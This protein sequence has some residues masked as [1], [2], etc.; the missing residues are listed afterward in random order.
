MTRIDCSALLFDLDGVLINSTPA[1]ARVWSQWAIEHGFSS[2]EVVGYAQGRPSIAT[3]RHFLP[4]TDHQAKN[5]EVER[6]EMED[7]DGVIPLPGA[8]ELL[9]SLP[10]DRWT[11]ATSCT[12][13]LAEV[14]IKAAGL[15]L[16][17]KLVS[18]NDVLRGKPDP[19]PYLKGAAAL[20]FPTANCVVFEDVPAGIRA[21]KAA[22]AKVIAFT[23]TF[24]GSGLLEAG[25]DWILKSCADV[26]LVSATESG[27]TLKLSTSSKP[28]SLP[29][30]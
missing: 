28:I 20:G 3:I 5:R 2:E 19:E 26:Q 27:L 14:R 24:P 22:G 11:I 21:G 17:R 6:R 4:D 15:P 10:E 16:P 7:L 9:A 18:S 29:A 25:A 12:R 23:T 8:L 30:T 1:V 13:L